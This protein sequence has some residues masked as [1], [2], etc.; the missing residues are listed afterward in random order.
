M[1]MIDQRKRKKVKK[2]KSKRD[3]R[4]RKKEKKITKDLICLCIA[5]TIPGTPAIVSK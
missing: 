5:A 1:L 3:E 4:R 2:K